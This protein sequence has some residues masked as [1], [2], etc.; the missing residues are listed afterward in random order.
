MSDKRNSKREFERRPRCFDLPL[1]TELNLGQSKSFPAVPSDLD[2]IKQKDLVPSLPTSALM[3][4]G[5][6]LLK[7]MDKE[8][9]NC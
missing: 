5:L 8:D 7:K 2:S 4:A 9:A 3:T 1:L 6:S